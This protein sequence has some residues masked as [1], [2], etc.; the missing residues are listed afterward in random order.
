[1]GKHVLSKLFQMNLIFKTKVS[2]MYF[3]YIQINQRIRS[4]TEFFSLEFANGKSSLLGNVLK[5]QL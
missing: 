1:M 3:L 2:Q 5:N 4:L